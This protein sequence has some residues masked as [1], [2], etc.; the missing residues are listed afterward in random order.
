[1]QDIVL[2]HPAA[3]KALSPGRVVIV[4][5]PAC[6]NVLGVVLKTS[7]TGSNNERV[8]TVL[9]ICDKNSDNS[10]N[11]S[12]NN[13]K[14][15]NTKNDQSQGSMLVKPVTKVKLFQPE[16]ACW[17]SLVQCRTDN[18]TIVTTKNM[19]VDPEKIMNDVKKREQPRFR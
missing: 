4:D 15:S 9:I 12:C 7:T 8:F 11:S 17:H 3:V 1:M 19:K 2:S 13:D 18:I 16:G 10:I 5:T 6:S 14:N